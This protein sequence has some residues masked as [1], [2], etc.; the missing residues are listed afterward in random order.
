M[1]KKITHTFEIKHTRKIYII[2]RENSNFYNYS[3]FKILYKKEQ[4]KSD[5]NNKKNLFHN[6]S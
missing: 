4:L 1:K 3:D 6:F 5:K 2:T